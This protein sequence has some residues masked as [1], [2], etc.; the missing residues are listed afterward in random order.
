VRVFKGKSPLSSPTF[1]QMN[2][3]RLDRSQYA[4]HSAKQNL[5]RSRELIEQAKELMRRVRKRQERNQ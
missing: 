2:R 1:E 5:V 3:E 4:S